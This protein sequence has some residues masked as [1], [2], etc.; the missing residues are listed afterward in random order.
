MPPIPKKNLEDPGF[1]KKRMTLEILNLNQGTTSHKKFMTKKI[2]LG[3]DMLHKYITRQ[4]QA[5]HRPITG[6]SQADNTPKTP[7]SHTDDTAINLCSN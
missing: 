1:C 6:P 7:Q 3:K 2:M 5:H 4:S